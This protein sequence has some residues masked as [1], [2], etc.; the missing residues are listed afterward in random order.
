MQVCISAPWHH[1]YVDFTMLDV[2]ILHH[3]TGVGAGQDQHLFF[4]ASILCYIC[5]ACTFRPCSEEQFITSIKFG[6]IDQLLQFAMNTIKDVS[7]MFK[8]QRKKS[9]KKTHQQ[10]QHIHKEFPSFFSRTSKVFIKALGPI[11]DSWT[12]VK[13]HECQWKSD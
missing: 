8:Q 10:L 2:H 6:F 13:P 3:T 9:V 11:L 12:L 1:L 7:H 4:T 5:L